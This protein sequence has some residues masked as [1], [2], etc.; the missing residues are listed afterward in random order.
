MK[1]LGSF[2]IVASMAVSHQAIAQTGYGFGQ[3]SVNVVSDNLYGL[4]DR[5]NQPDVG[6]LYHSGYTDLLEHRFDSAASFFEQAASSPM[7][8]HKVAY[9]AGASH[10]LTGNADKASFYLRKAL[11]GGALALPTEDRKIAREMLAEIKSRR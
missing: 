10:F 3:D 1:L 2:L 8:N 11:R 4:Y 9:L 5:I 7:A 6:E